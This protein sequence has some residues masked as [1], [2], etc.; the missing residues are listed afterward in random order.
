MNLL[1]YKGI[2]SVLQYNE[3]EMKQFIR[4][5]STKQLVLLCKHKLLFSIDV[6]LYPER[7]ISKW[8]K[9]SCNSRKLILHDNIG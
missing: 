2:F 8:I 1:R 4:L 9:H 3:E 5:R 7:N 6:Y